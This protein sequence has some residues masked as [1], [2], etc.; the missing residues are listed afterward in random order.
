[1]FDFIARELSGRGIE[2]VQAF[3]LGGLASW[4]IGHWRRRRQRQSVLRGD[5]RDTVVIEQHI[6]E[7]AEVPDPECPGQT[8]KVPAVLRIRALGQA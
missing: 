5:A 3:L 2:A 7:A 6:V 1:M 8:R 4:A